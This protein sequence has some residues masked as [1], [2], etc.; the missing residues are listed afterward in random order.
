LE[1]SLN[2]VPPQSLEAEQ[3][4][5]G[6][7]MIEIDA[8][9]KARQI[10][11]SSDFYR[12]AHRDIFNAVCALADRETPIDIITVQEELRSRGKLDEVGGTAY[13]MA[14][15]DSVPTAANVEYHS[16]IV[17]EKALRRRAMAAATEI[18]GHA[19]DQ[20]LDPDVMLQRITEAVLELQ[21]HKGGKG[22]V[23]LKDAMISAYDSLAERM[24]AGGIKPTVKWNVGC[25]DRATIGIQPGFTLIAAR[26]SEG[27]TALMLQAL[28]SSREHGPHLVFSLE[29]EEEALV[30]R[31]FAAK[32]RIDLQRIRMGTTV[33]SELGRVANIVNDHYDADNI[34]L[35]TDCYDISSIV[36][37]TKMAIMR[38]GITC[39]WID[40][41]QM[42][43]APGQT[44]R[45]RCNVVSR[46]LKRLYTQHNIRVIAAAQLNRMPES[47]RPAAKKKKS[48]D[49]GTAAKLPDPT[50]RLSDLAETDQLGRD[51]DL[52]VLIDNPKKTGNCWLVV[53]KQKDGPT[54]NY[55]CWYEPSTLTFHEG[56]EE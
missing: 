34:I 6:S 42:V 9:Y 31:M 2:K 49:E 36:A 41:A 10:V 35:R 18:L 27:K 25:I 15:F 55:R 13:L 39:V 23:T 51:A 33:D 46:A 3:S 7:M 8:I 44:E 54:G 14:L 47:R 53:A 26:M 16:N 28:E 12:P 45:E 56:W 20:E 17:A 11:K 38:H 48:E 21:K 29:T 37:E 5:L 19:Q 22:G 50:V 1:K 24:A 4:T 30:N 43:E 32:G 52:A 40:Y